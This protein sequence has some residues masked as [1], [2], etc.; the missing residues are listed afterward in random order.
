MLDEAIVYGYIR[1]VGGE[2]DGLNLQ[3][4]REVNINAL[5]GLPALEEGTLVYRDR[6]SVGILPTKT[7]RHQGA[8]LDP[9]MI[10]PVQRDVGP[11]W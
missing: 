4:R 1:D 6:G 9:Y 5:Q 11:R 3:A 8:G 7:L 10:R 2:F